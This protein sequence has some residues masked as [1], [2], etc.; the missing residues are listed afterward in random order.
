VVLTAMAPYTEAEL[1]G[2]KITPE[3]G[4]QVQAIWKQLHEE[5]ATW[6]SRS[7][8]RVLPNS[9]HNIQLEDPDAV[10]EAV[11]SVVRAGGPTEAR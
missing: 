6:S 8:H 7:T 9:G 2:M 10:V 11:L 5:E 4:R 1:R 3:Q